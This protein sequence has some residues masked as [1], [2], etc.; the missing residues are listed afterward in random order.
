MSVLTR[1]S[2]LAYLP[3]EDGGRLPLCEM[4]DDLQEER[5]D[6]TATMYR[7]IEAMLGHCPDEACGHVVEQLVADAR[8]LGEAAAEEVAASAS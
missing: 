5:Q 4:W 3:S 6:P 2:D 1:L 8:R 7:R